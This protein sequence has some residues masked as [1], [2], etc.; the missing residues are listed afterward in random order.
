MRNGYR[1]IDMDTHVSP[2]GDM[3]ENY[4]DPSFAS[5]LPELALYRKNRTTSDGVA[6]FDLSIA[7]V[8][9]N[10]KPGEPLKPEHLEAVPGGGRAVVAGA[11]PKNAA[12]L[13]GHHRKATYEG[14]DAE[15]R[16]EDMDLE[17]RD[18][19]F[20]FSGPWAAAM[21]KLG[22]PTLSEG[23]YRAY[24]RWLRDFTHGHTDRLK[25]HAQLPAND[26]EWAIAEVKT[27]AKEDWAGGV[28]VH[29]SENLTI[30][31][32]SL[33]P[34]W[35]VLNDLDMPIVHH[36]F[37]TDWPYFPGYRDMWGHVAISRTAAHPWGAAR[38]CS[39]L[40]CGGIFDRYPNLRAEV[41]EVGHGWL[42]HWAIR[43]SEQVWYRAGST[44]DIKQSPIE[45][46]QEG[47]FRCAAE[48]M[49]GPAMTKACY[50]ILGN[51]PLMHQ[52]DYP[53]GEAFFPDTA[54][55]VMDWP[56]WKELGEDTL[57]HHMS[58]NAADFF[59]SRL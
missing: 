59:G 32:P 4:M 58:G 17:G 57:R 36:S 39:Y 56:I 25:A 19:D 54:G 29:L 3:L 28:W 26:V 52:S 42:P 43:L 27:L 51:K 50:D 16:I 53:H 23:V 35:A 8:P 40:I 21:Q 14:F 7:P 9:F 48:P 20:M 5:R 49:E 22:D 31:D 24:H 44:P 1:I 38:L 33:E 55:M 13:P 34:L 47:R 10:R 6:V 12:G 11:A 2:P 30:D 15:G 37:Y 46:I 45:Y 41:S 18:I